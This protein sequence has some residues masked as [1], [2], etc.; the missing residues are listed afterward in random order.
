MNVLK[1]TPFKTLAILGVAAV[2]AVSCSTDN[3]EADFTITA[4]DVK[5]V[6]ETDNYTDV[7]DNA[8]TEAFMNRSASG[9]SAETIG[10][11][12]DCYTATYNNTGYTITF[13]NCMLNTTENVN[14]MVTVAYS[15]SAESGVFTATFIDFYVDTTK[16][17]GTRTYTM[18]SSS[19]ENSVSFSVISDMTVTLAN[20][21]E[22][23]EEGTKTIAFSIV[24]NALY[25]SISGNWSIMVNS[26]TYVVSVTT[27]LQSVLGCE[28]VSQ[29]TMN[30]SKNGLQVSVDF[31]DGTC[32]DN[33]TVTYPNGTVKNITL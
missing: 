19:T 15:G 22:I 2:L 3:E 23:K 7:A 32:D 5:Q 9:K 17:N 21:N 4:Q 26:D 6:F 30:L 29:G 27:P 24:D 25:L 10:K 1:R 31:G 20:N 14:G 11:D 12:N 28:Y 8:I 16:L 33:A 18:T 13:N